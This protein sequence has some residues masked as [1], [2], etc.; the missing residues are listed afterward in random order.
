LS[1]EDGYFQTPFRQ[2]LKPA[3]GTQ[4]NATGPVRLDGPRFR[5]IGD[6]ESHPASGYR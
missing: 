6:T 2:A 5:R 4:G 1:A 3:P